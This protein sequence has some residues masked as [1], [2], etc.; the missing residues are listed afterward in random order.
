MGERA[1][2][3][4]MDVLSQPAVLIAAISF[5]GLLLQKKPAN[6]IVKGTTKSF[7][8][9]IVISAGAG[10]LVGSLEPFGK[11]F[12]AAFHVNGVVPNNEAIV[13]MALNEYGTATALI[14]FF[15]MLSNI[16]IAR[17]TRLKYI[18]LT[19]HHTLY[20]ACLIAVI[21]A[22]AGLK[23]PFL[24][25]VGA[26]SLGLTMSVFPAMVQPF[27][28]K[29]TGN[30]K[31]AFGHFSSIGYA[32]SGLIG[33]AA[34]KGSRSTEKIRFPKGLGFLRDS[35]VSIALTMTIL[36]VLIALFAGA[37]YV[38]RELSGGTHYL[39][40][41]V[42]QAVTFAAGV[43]I[44]LSGVRLVLAEIV[45]AFKGISDKLV[46]DSKPAL[47][48]PIIFPYAP[49]A[50]LIGFFCSFIGGI[51]GMLI[52]GAAG[53]VIV[54]PGVV[55]H[56]FTGASAGVFGNAA[57]GIRGAVLG[58]FVNGLIITFFPVFLL[59]VMGDLGFANTTFSD[60]DFAA[61]GIVLGHALKLLGAGGVVIGIAAVVA[62]AV[63]LGFKRGKA[64]KSDH[65]AEA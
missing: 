56:F 7:L 25:G 2:K 64:G 18:F 14:M 4:M 26:V 41:S 42:I 30:D 31:V 53:A 23:G 59:P 20:M 51:T 63:L 13:A 19:G 28:K 22:V 65:K 33:K 37:G 27:M 58:S 55:P 24:I 61:T 32:V 54:L 50:V 15:G 11:M 3:L 45:P 9:F 48:C 44:I 16:L 47:D 49:N 6:E 36:Y 10:I 60:T 29:I 40:F 5:I 46:P 62:G 38:E 8:G 34:G 1:L 17:F 12:Q 52:L 39:V 57:G 21:L 43:F 35:S